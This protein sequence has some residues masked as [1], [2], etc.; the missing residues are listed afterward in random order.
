MSSTHPTARIRYARSPRRSAGALRELPARL[1][2][3]D[4]LDRGIQIDALDGVAD[5][6]AIEDV[7]DVGDRDD[8]E[9][10]L[11]LPQAVLDAG[12]DIFEVERVVPVDPLGVAHRDAS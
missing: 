7:A 5:V 11:V 10:A 8:H 12:A 1:G 9:V 2:G 6:A 3:R 4:L